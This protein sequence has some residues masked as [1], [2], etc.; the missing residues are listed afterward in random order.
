MVF[1]FVGLFLKMSFFKVW[2]YFKKN[3]SIDFHKRG[4][5]LLEIYLAMAEKVGNI[6]NILLNNFKMVKS[7]KEHKNSR[8]SWI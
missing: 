5:E 4:P 8:N 7:T 6:K 1:F 3:Y 2:R